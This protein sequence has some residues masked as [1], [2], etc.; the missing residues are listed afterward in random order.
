MST[1]PAALVGEVAIVGAGA[2]GGAMARRLRQ[3]GLAVRVRDPDPACEQRARA[4]G[5]SVW[6]SAAAAARGARWLIVAVTDA[7]E[8]EAVLFGP[9][10]AA[11]AL[12]AGATVLLCPTLG[13]E[14]VADLGERLLARGLAVLDAPMS[15]GPARAESGTMSLMLAGAAKT[16]AAAEPL[17]ARLSNQRFA[18]GP[19]LGDAART[20]LVN[21]LLAAAN[22]AAAAEALQLATRLGLDPARTLEVIAASSGASWIALDRARRAHAGDT[23]V[24]ARTALLAKDSALAAAAARPHGGLGPLGAA[25]CERFAQAMAAGLG[26]ADD[27]AVLSLPA[28]PRGPADAP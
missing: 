23:A 26:E 3:C 28:A 1:G 18:L 24:H 16:L 5:C 10:G 11:A 6:P 4:A 19:C 2:M 12:D 7:A 22:L 8:S 20:K 13:P 21:N 14:T 17:L 25:A 9:D 15:G 27:S